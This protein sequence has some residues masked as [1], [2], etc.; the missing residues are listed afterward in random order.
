L[1]ENRFSYSNYDAEGRII[2]AGEAISGTGYGSCMLLFDLNDAADPFSVDYF[3]DREYKPGEYTIIGESYPPPF[4]YSERTYTYYDK[5]ATDFPFPTNP[6]KFLRGKVS[7]T[8]NDNS[9]TWYSYSYDGR[10][11]IVVTRINGLDTDGNGIANE[12]NDLVVLQYN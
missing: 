2:V 1:A 5:A 12:T 8:W 4:G 10:I 6:Q 11:D 7:K 9:T 3:L